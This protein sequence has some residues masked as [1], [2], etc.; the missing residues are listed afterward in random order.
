ML[1]RSGL[2]S[3]H[4]LSSGA[5]QPERVLPHLAGVGGS[6]G[7]GQTELSQGCDRP[8]V[9]KHDEREQGRCGPRAGRPNCERRPIAGVHLLYEVTRCTTLTT[10][11][12]TADNMKGR[13][14]K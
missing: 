13:F 5:F 2:L 11:C 6:D 14:F 12:V 3:N 4:L 10:G 8:P 9:K 1:K 7:A